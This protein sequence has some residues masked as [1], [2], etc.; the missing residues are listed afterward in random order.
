MR[1]FSSLDNKIEE[2][3]AKPVTSIAQLDHTHIYYKKITIVAISIIESA[4]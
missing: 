2:D 1:S 3:I 4:L